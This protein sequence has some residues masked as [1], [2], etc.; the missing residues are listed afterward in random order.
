MAQLSDNESEMEIM[1]EDDDECDPL[2]NPTPGDSSTFVNLEPVQPVD[3]PIEDLP[4]SMFNHVDI[5]TGAYDEF[6][7]GEAITLSAT[8]ASPSPILST[9]SS[10]I[11]SSTV[12][13]SSRKNEDATK[14]YKGLRKEIKPHDITWKA[15]LPEATEIQLPIDLFRTIITDSMVARLVDQTNLSQRENKR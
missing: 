9:S 5:F 1:S 14:E 8:E 4:L 10:S 11:S 3:D 13:T 15:T 6:D 12:S 7:G 2:W